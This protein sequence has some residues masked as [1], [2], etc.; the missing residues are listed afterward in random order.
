MPSS[1][2]LYKDPDSGKIIRTDSGML[3]GSPKCCCGPC[4][5]V[6]IQIYVHD[7]YCDNGSGGSH[8]DDQCDY[9]SPTFTLT[10]KCDG[11]DKSFD[12][13][14]YPH[15]GGY[16]PG[17]GTSSH[18]GSKCIKI[19]GDCTFDPYNFFSQSE[20][21]RL[22]KFYDKW[23]ISVTEYTDQSQQ[24]YRPYCNRDNPA[25]YLVEIHLQMKLFHVCLEFDIFAE[26]EPPM[27]PSYL[28]F[29]TNCPA[30]ANMSESGYGMLERNDSYWPSSTSKRYEYSGWICGCRAEQMGLLDCFD[31]RDSNDEPIPVIASVAVDCSSYPSG[32]N[33]VDVTISNRGGSSPCDCH[34]YGYGSF[35]Y[36][37][38]HATVLVVNR[39]ENAGTSGC[40]LELTLDSMAYDAGFRFGDHLYDGSRDWTVYGGSSS[41]VV[42]CGVRYNVFGS[43]PLSYP[44]STDIGYLS[45]G[46]ISGR[47]YGDGCD[48]SHFS[49]IGMYGGAI[50]CEGSDYIVFMVEQQVKI[51]VLLDLAELC[52]CPYCTPDF[53]SIKI[54]IVKDDDTTSTYS[55]DVPL[56]PTSRPSQRP[57]GAYVCQTC[58]PSSG[59]DPAP[60]YLEGEAWVCDW[61]PE[62]IAGIEL[63]N[64]CSM[65]PWYVEWHAGFSGYDLYLLAGPGAAND[66]TQ[67]YCAAIPIYDP[68]ENGL[69][70]DDD[71]NDRFVSE[72]SVTWEALFPGGGTKT[73]PIG[74]EYDPGCP[75]HYL[76]SALEDCG[77][78]DPVST[79]TL[80][81]GYRFVSDGTQGYWESVPQTGCCRN[82]YE[83]SQPLDKL[84]TFS[85][86][87]LVSTECRNLVG[88]ACWS[89]SVGD[90]GTTVSG[91]AHP[92]D[93]GGS[94]GFGFHIFGSFWLSDLVSAD[95]SPDCDGGVQLHVTYPCN[96]NRDYH[97]T[98]SRRE[99]NFRFSGSIPDDHHT[100]CIKAIIN[101]ISHPCDNWS[102]IRITFPATV[103][104]QPPVGSS[105][106]ITLT[107]E[108]V[109][110]T[111][112]PSG[113]VCYNCTVR[114]DIESASSGVSAVPTAPSRANYT[115]VADS[116][117]S[118]GWVGDTY[119]VYFKVVHDTVKVTVKDKNGAT[120]SVRQEVCS[121]LPNKPHNASGGGL[122][123]L[124]FDP[125]SI[126]TDPDD[127]NV[128]RLADGTRLDSE[129]WP[130]TVPHP[131]A[132]KAG[133]QPL[134]IEI[135]EKWG[136]RMY[137]K[138]SIECL[139]LGAPNPLPD[140]LL[141]EP[142]GL[143]S[144]PGKGVVIPG[145]PEQGEEDKYYAT[146]LRNG[147]SYEGTCVIEIP[148]GETVSVNG[149]YELKTVEGEEKAVLVE[150]PHIPDNGEF[151]ASASEDDESFSLEVTG[152]AKY[153]FADIT[154][155][156]KF[157]GKQHPYA[158]SI[159][160]PLDGWRYKFTHSDPE[161]GYL[162]GSNEYPE[163]ISEPQ[164][165]WNYMYLVPSMRVEVSVSDADS[166]TGEPTGEPFYSIE[167]TQAYMPASCYPY[168]KYGPKN[169]IVIEN[170]Q[171]F[172]NYFS[173]EV[174]R[175]NPVVDSRSL[176]EDEEWDTA[177]VKNK[178]PNDS[179]GTPFTE[180]LDDPE[181]AEVIP[182][183]IEGEEPV[184]DEPDPCKSLDL[185]LCAT[186]HA[187][188]P[189]RYNAYLLDFYGPGK[190]DLIIPF[191]ADLAYVFPQTPVLCGYEFEEWRMLDENE[192]ALFH[193]DYPSVLQIPTFELPDPPVMPDYPIVAKS[194]WTVL[195][196][197]ITYVTECVGCTQDPEEVTSG[198]PFPDGSP[199][200]QAVDD[201]IATLPATYTVEDLPISLSGMPDFSSATPPY[202]GL[203]GILKDGEF[204]PV[205][206][207]KKDETCGDLTISIRYEYAGVRYNIGFSKAYE[208]CDVDGQQPGLPF[209]AGS[210]ERQ[211]VD[212]WISSIP[213]TYRVVD[214]P[215]SLA[216]LPNFPSS[217]PAYEGLVGIVSGGEFVPTDSIP[218]DS[219]TDITVGIRYLQSGCVYDVTYV[220][221]YGT[222]ESGGTFVPGL[223]FPAGS[224]ERQDVEDW[225]S[226]LPATYT[227]D[228]LPISL[229]GIPSFTSSNPSYAGI[230]GIRENGMFVLANSIPE[231]TRGD[232]VV[233]IRYLT[234]HLPVNSNILVP[235]INGGFEPYPGGNPI[236][237]PG[238]YKP[239]DGTVC[240][241][242]DSSASSSLQCL[243]LTL[244]YDQD[245]QHPL[246]NNCFNAA[247]FPNGITVYGL[248]IPP[249]P[250]LPPPPAT[251]QYTVKHVYCRSTVPGEGECWRL[252]ETKTTQ[253]GSMSNAVPFAVVPSDPDFN[254]SDFIYDPPEQVPVDRE[255]IVV[256]INYYYDDDDWIT[257]AWRLKNCLT[258]EW[259][260]I[261]QAYR[262]GDRVVPPAF[263]VCPDKPV[264]IGWDPDPSM[265]I[266]GVNWVP[267]ITAVYPGDPEEYAEVWVYDDHEE[268]ITLLD[269]V[270]NVKITSK[271]S[272][273][274]S[275]PSPGMNGTHVITE[276]GQTRAEI[277]TF[278]GW[279]TS[280][281][282]VIGADPN[283]GGIYISEDTTL[284]SVYKKESPVFECDGSYFMEWSEIRNVCGKTVEVL[285]SER[286]KRSIAIEC[287]VTI[288]LNGF[289]LSYAGVPGG[290]VTDVF[291]SITSDDVVINGADPVSG[292]KGGFETEGRSCVVVNTAPSADPEGDPDVVMSGIVLSSAGACLTMTSGA[293]EMED[294]ELKG[295]TTKAAGNT[296]AFLYLRGDRNMST[297]F[298]PNVDNDVC[299]Q[300]MSLEFTQYGV[301]PDDVSMWLI[302]DEFTSKRSD[303]SRVEL[304]FSKSL[305]VDNG[306]VAMLG[307]N[308]AVYATADDSVTETSSD[309]YARYTRVYYRLR[310]MSN[311]QPVATGTR[312]VAN[313]RPYFI[314]SVAYT[315]YTDPE[316]FQYSECYVR[317]H[318]H[319]GSNVSGSSS[320]YWA[321]VDHLDTVVAEFSKDEYTGNVSGR[322]RLADTISSESCSASIDISE[323][324][325]SIK[326]GDT[327]S[328]P[329]SLYS[330][331]EILA[332]LDPALI[333]VQDPAVPSTQSKYNLMAVG[334]YEKHLYLDY[335][336]DS[337]TISS[338][339][340]QA[341]FG[342]TSGRSRMLPNPTYGP[343]S[344][345]KATIS[346]NPSAVFELDRSTDSQYWILYMTVGSGIDLY[347]VSLA[348][349]ESLWD[350]GV[351]T[352]GTDMSVFEYLDYILSYTSYL[353]DTGH[354]VAGHWAGRYLPKICE[355]PK[356]LNNNIWVT[357]PNETIKYCACTDADIQS[358]FYI[359]YRIEL[360]DGL[361][362][363]GIAPFDPS[364]VH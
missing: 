151:T 145:D 243:S 112:S 341:T 34:F 314:L 267:N 194:V 104:E 287:P 199:E 81:S 326:A 141:F 94:A 146:V 191:V 203:V 296:N 97:F 111:D 301:S 62:R 303:A 318:Y 168:N 18:E 142:E 100:Y 294:F 255:G 362:G 332:N 132:A 225:M 336:L 349:T 44:C 133:E 55:I 182:D 54:T 68:C 216:G 58:P 184:G 229:E 244:Y 33:T 233:V 107:D 193:A 238:V 325:R 319:N 109:K 307:G 56:Q 254:Q 152:Y 23:I 217:T 338:S 262:P 345:W 183:E 274:I 230:V 121:A 218:V 154:M 196:Y 38:K 72:G 350:Y 285:R 35:T 276:Q 263:P 226:T 117:K 140:R 7:D 113:M 60:A 235:G 64:N 320:L 43:V 221:E 105:N 82:R 19:C 124:G 339:E 49:V 161:S 3:A 260:V 42:V 153:I 261:L 47:P 110:R 175:T 266:A 16:Y 90:C 310:Y 158:Q 144:E 41:S 25:D 207:L 22:N 323:T 322:V 53:V 363:S 231:G 26:L 279:S 69:F 206:S 282:D 342:R 304:Y 201:W 172:S 312:P 343:S 344:Q 115:I 61:R 138:V 87:I 57:A 15:S 212:S 74:S 83:W 122:V 227:T 88:D 258:D 135:D 155:I 32:S 361:V 198:L 278:V 128:R 268:Q 265:M 120:A 356:S 359:T 219:H 103:S 351:N 86:D 248:C 188:Y 247:D 76:A 284:F 119:V 173:A 222:Y 185:Q 126:F 48:S 129:G 176:E 14:T 177:S 334:G 224:P 31:R 189:V 29:T 223:P 51:N 12:I 24:Q 6:L 317:L 118:P 329:S 264:P 171:F 1:V 292:S 46:R 131:W 195:E 352:Y 127:P 4:K 290:G 78:W 125:G 40:G 106:V 114:E 11:G 311:G 63:S 169:H 324:L 99:G 208:T 13:P 272:D 192:I 95:C 28:S 148:S 246:V 283:F 179:V 143:I 308:K 75:D 89:I 293:L 259:Y 108:D 249:P 174:V 347:Q 280:P 211:A 186:M 85:A 101:G 330:S 288:N 134:E 321:D 36:D 256:T 316:Y 354:V 116:G 39:C 273:Y 234:D 17:Y 357:K 335:F 275:E 200:K 164:H 360:K 197:T 271:L 37:T 102:G 187:W 147:N 331:A 346:G 306:W 237:S 299:Q 178:D 166:E 162:C 313:Q 309:D 8:Y 9:C 157:V 250:P 80:P 291:V 21:E 65:T 190:G 228:D 59:G 315:L 5:Y 73:V 340:S 50:S 77:D 241:D 70:Y 364:V 163:C 160:A 79:P 30:I 358:W 298:V 232:I 27:W 214:L 10:L 180:I 333:L 156:G 328:I 242:I 300:R 252:Y 123:F 96:G 302:S 327:I 20:T 281:D 170:P 67:W 251:Y 210:P 98:G 159:V 270:Q 337:V 209:P 355:W 269:H 150:N 71:D 149:F 66:C 91:I 213:T 84:F 236:L 353:D 93:Q 130:L 220:T 92:G 245:F 289:T 277:W 205:D 137:V 136:S 181:V 295:T 253:P 215:I 204:T 239:T 348:Y 202:K 257:I 45:S 52:E 167:M 240:L 305:G 165:S 286:L 297:D 139:E 2:T